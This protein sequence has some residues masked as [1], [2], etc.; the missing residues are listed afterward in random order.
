V[1]IHIA[2]TLRDCL[3]SDDFTARIG[4]DEFVIVI[5]G[6]DV[7]TVEKVAQRII[8]SVAR[9]ALIEREECELSV[10]VGIATDHR[11]QRTL[12]QML[13]SADI[14]LYRAKHNGRGRFE[15]FDTETLE[16]VGVE[17]LARWNHP[18]RGVLPPCEFLEMAESEKRLVDLDRTILRAAMADA[19]ELLAAG[20]IMPALSVNVSSQSLASSEFIDCIRQMEPFPNHLCFELVESMLLDEPSGVVTANL[21]GLRELGVSLDIDDFG[22]GHA[23]LLGMLEARPDRVKID[24]RLVMPMCESQKHLDLVKSIVQIAESLGMSTIA[25]GVESEGHRVKLKEIGCDS[26]QGF[27]FARPMPLSELKSMLLRKAA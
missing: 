14:A 11:G 17:A 27:G 10:S 5:D 4:G 23:S 24:R 13:K 3:R 16:C 15:Q 25:E 6:A 1:L 22:S 12:N 9:P 26:I 8:T 21:D 18:E 2:K 7:D 19:R 20:T